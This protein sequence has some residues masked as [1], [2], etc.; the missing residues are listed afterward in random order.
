[1]V[2]MTSLMTA[3]EYLATGDE[4]PRFTELIDGEIIV[5]TPSVRHQ[6]IA[7]E[8]RFLL[9]LWCREVSGRGESPDPVDARLDPGNVYAPDVWWVS[10]MHRPD[11]DAS[12]LNG[13]PDLAIEVRSPSTWRFDVG[14]KRETYERAGLPELWLVDTASHTIIVYRRST[15]DVASF[16]VALEVGAGETLESPQLPGFRLNIAALFDR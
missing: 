3:D 4:L 9:N 2:A 16:D 7:N 8:I 12:H 6:R 13:P 10:E 1:M 14:V 15:P 5:N 11:R